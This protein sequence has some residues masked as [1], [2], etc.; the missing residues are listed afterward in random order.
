MPV[1]STWYSAGDA[2][3]AQSERTA[4]Q[5]VRE[6]QKLFVSMTISERRHVDPS[7]VPTVG[8]C[9]G[10]CGDPKERGFSYE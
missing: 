4:M 1:L 10:T 9:L 8:Q 5:L 7:P 3:K 6:L 2:S